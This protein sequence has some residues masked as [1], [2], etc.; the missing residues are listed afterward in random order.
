[1]YK[2]SETASPSKPQQRKRGR[3]PKVKEPAPQEELETA[4][5]AETQD[6]AEPM[7]T[8]ETS[9]E[10]PAA[11]EMAE[12]SIVDQQEVTTAS[13]EA[14]IETE[15]AVVED[16]QPAGMSSAVET[17]DA[18]ALSN[19]WNSPVILGGKPEERDVTQMRAD[20]EDDESPAIVQP[21]TAQVQDHVVGFTSY[22]CHGS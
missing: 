18:V 19:T 12:P 6:A 21:V 9:A 11:S 3:P 13:G 14:A 1:M 2:E 8:E 17:S 15:P 4:P 10:A 20:D 7:S 22:L 16:S 5:P